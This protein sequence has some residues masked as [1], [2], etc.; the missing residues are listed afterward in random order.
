M[1]CLHTTRQTGVVLQT[2]AR[3]KFGKFLRFTCFLLDTKN[4]TMYCRLKKIKSIT[5]RGLFGR[6]HIYTENAESP[7]KR[8]ITMP[9]LSTF[10]LH[11]VRTATETNAECSPVV[12]DVLLFTLS[13]NEPPGLTTS[14]SGATVPLT[15]RT[16]THRSSRGTQKHSTL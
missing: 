4:R 1:P 7:Q 2:H 14:S 11:A 16:H 5:W 8:N 10:H 9:M 15:V 12:R 3:L 6:I 13:D